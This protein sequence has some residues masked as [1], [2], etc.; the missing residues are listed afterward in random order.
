M[1]PR[2]NLYGGPGVGKST[3]ASMIFTRLKQHGQHVELVQEVVKQLVYADRRLTPWDQVH[4]FG[5]QFGVELLPLQGGVDRIVTDSPLLLQVIYAELN[6]CPSYVSLRGICRDFD[7]AYPTIDFFIRRN[8]TNYQRFGRW[9]D[10]GEALKLDQIIED[11][12]ISRGSPYT[13]LD[14][15]I[16]ASVENCFA[17]LE[18]P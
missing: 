4:I 14:P 17:L 5:Q 1:I 10:L 7:K 18:T 8:P 3:M 16:P 13:K 12:L 2:I 9:Q 15:Q 11:A 6:D